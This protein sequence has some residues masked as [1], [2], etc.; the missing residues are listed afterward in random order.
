MTCK[1]TIRQLDGELKRDDEHTFVGVCAIMWSL[2]YFDLVKLF[3]YCLVKDR[4]MLECFKVL[5]VKYY[6]LW[7]T[8]WV[9]LR[10]A[11]YKL[12]Q[13]VEDVIYGNHG[14]GC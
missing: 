1:D 14:T 2:S 13:K 5:K 7:K 12:C 8:K 6:F 4:E 9:L 11:Y 10:V 3:L